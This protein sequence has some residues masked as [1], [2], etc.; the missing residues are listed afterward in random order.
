[1]IETLLFII[2]LPF[3]AFSLLFMAIGII[4]FV[5]GYAKHLEKKRG[6]KNAKKKRID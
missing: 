1:M 4:G 3:A 6:A 2:L 5:G